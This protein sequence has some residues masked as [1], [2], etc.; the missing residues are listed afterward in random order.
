MEY[1]TPYQN[2]HFFS[3]SADQQSCAFPVFVKIVQTS[4]LPAVAERVRGW[5]KRRPHT[6]MHRDSG[7]TLLHFV[8]ISGGQSFQLLL[9]PY[10]SFE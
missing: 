2:P 10:Y 4:S 7:D 5:A 3:T 6:R 8:T 9:N 1:F